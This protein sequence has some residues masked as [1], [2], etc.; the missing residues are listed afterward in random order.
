MKTQEKKTI[1][2]KQETLVKGAMELLGDVLKEKNV[3]IGGYK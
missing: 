3:R 1:D 2:I